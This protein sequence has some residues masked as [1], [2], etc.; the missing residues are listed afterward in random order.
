MSARG[1]PSGRL[2]RRRLFQAALVAG[3][4]VTLGACAAPST[5]GSAA[6][7]RPVRVL[8][9]TNEP[10]G[11]YHAEPL[12]AEAQRRGW[13]LTQLVPDRSEIDADEAVPVAVAG[14]FPEADLLVVTGAGDW[15]ADCLAQLPALPVVASSLAYLLPQEAP[16]AGEVRSRVGAAT[17]SSSAEAAAFR[18]HLG[19][20]GEARVVGSA[21]TDDLP[22]RAAEPGTVLVLTSVTHE[23]ET[24][25]AAPGAQLLL[26]SARR[27]AD[28][29]RRIVVGLHPREDRELWSEYE[30][31]EV[32]SVQ[33]SAVAEVAIGI[34]GTVFPLVAAVG[35]P[36]VGCIDPALEI[37]DHLRDVCSAVIDDA[38]AAVAAVDTARPLAADALTAAVGPVGGSA[39][40]LLDVWGD[41][42]AGAGG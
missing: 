37:P 31:S 17:A 21:Q 20:P 12:L 24:G 38:G 8:I 1:G 39:Q 41:A 25:A 14:A 7:P 26:D 42:V 28:A 36:L 35:T 3:G 4:A 32:P 19:L 18:A 15:P 5:S 6:A 29:G 33:A 2:S 13:T 27:L 30:I 23:D 22:Q 40:R 34:P 16:R 9:A 10:W 11:T